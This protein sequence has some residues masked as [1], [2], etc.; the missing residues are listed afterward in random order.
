MHKIT[1]SVNDPT[2]SGVG[3]LLQCSTGAVN[4]TEVVFID[5]FIAMHHF[6]ESSNK[7]L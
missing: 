2:G 1:A 6:P 5:I 3:T 4:I 7:P